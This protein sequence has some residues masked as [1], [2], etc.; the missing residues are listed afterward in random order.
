M[1]YKDRIDRVERSIEESREAA[2]MPSDVA[3]RV[4]TIAMH[5]A[6]AGGSV[7]L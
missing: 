3:L 2:S 5:S 7:P 1:N 4:P 6:S